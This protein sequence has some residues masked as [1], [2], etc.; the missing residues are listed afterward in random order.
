MEKNLE[1]VRNLGLVAHS[2]AGKTSLGEAPLFITKTTDRLGRV[3]DGTSVLDFEPEE[4]KR[5]L[6]ISTAFHHYDWKKHRVFFAD[7]PG[8]DNFI[9]DTFAC[10]QV[11]DGL[12]LVVDAMD[13]VKVQTE[14]VWHLADQYGIPRLIF[15]NKLD[16]ERADFPRPWTP[17]RPYS[18][19]RPVPLTLPIGGGETLS[20]LVSLLDQKAYGYHDGGSARNS[21]CRLTWST[22][23]SPSG[24]NSSRASPRPMTPWW[25]NTWKGRN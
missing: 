21:P 17:F 25:K 13:G 24:S 18:K 15:I 20:G 12:V 11:L 22:K 5:T 9:A 6:T 19:P 23:S 14:R 8:D 2:G 7:T 10:L 1:K 3:D 16:R 4:I